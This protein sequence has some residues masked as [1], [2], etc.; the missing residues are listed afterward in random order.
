MDASRMSTK[1]WVNIILLGLGFMLLFSA[2]QT[3][4]FVQSIT[5]FSFLSPECRNDGD[6]SKDVVDGGITISQDFATKIGY[7]SLCIIYLMV[8]IGNWIS[9][10][11]VAVI[12]P[13]LSL[14]VTGFLY[15]VY[16]AAIIRPYV[17]AIFVGAFIL[18]TAGGVLWTA[19]GQLLIQNSSRERMG[20]TSGIFW[21]MLQLRYVFVCSRPSG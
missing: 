18:G 17:P 11:V 12:G 1:N 13:K 15:V 20:T 9:V 10:S 7:Y 2:F 8:A 6:T 16:I 5:I 4:A 3:T 19:Q 14:I 21:L